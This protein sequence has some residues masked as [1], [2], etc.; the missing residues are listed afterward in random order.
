ML[1]CPSTHR[2]GSVH[3]SSAAAVAGRAVL[4]A[5]LALLQASDPPGSRPFCARPARDARRVRRSA[6]RVR[7]RAHCSRR[8]HRSARWRQ[9]RGGKVA[10]AAAA[11]GRCT[12]T[13]RRGC[14]TAQR[15]AE[16]ARHLGRHA[17]VPRRRR[18]ARLPRLHAQRL[19]ARRRLAGGPAVHQRALPLAALRRCEAHVQ[20]LPRIGTEQG[21]RS[22]FFPLRSRT[23]SRCSP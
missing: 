17:R 6:Q 10:A 11:A 21:D 14:Q 23:R 7:Q 5:R 16:L 13:K 4:P 8:R 22:C 9:G 20:H 2:N 19:A 1:R 18:A 3:R 15:T 12:G